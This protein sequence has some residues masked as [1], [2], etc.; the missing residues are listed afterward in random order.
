MSRR[1]R[2]RPV[3]PHVRYHH[4]PD[5]DADDARRRISAAYGLILCAAARRLESPPERAK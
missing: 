1:E 4:N 3:Q 2:H 5:L